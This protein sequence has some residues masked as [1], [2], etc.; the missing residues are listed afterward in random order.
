LVSLEHQ[1]WLNGDTAKNA[2]LM[3]VGFLPALASH[4]DTNPP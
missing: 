3:P 1:S 2:I 4:G